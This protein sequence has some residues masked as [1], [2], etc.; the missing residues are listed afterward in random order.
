MLPPGPNSPAA[1]QI[2]QFTLRPLPYLEECLQR[3]GDPFTLR[4][5]SLGTYVALTAPELV[6]Q[7]FTAGSDQLLAG[8]ANAIVEPIVGKQSILLTDGAT[9]L[10]KRRL[11]MPPLH[12]DRMH[13]YGQVMADIAAE[14]L[15]RMPTGSVFSLHPHMQSI[16]MKVILRTVFGVER[17]SNMQELEQLLTA[18]LQ[19]PPAVLTFIPV[20]YLDFPL[21]PYRTLMRRRKAVE[22]QLLDLIHTARREQANAPEGA[23]ASPGRL[24]VLSLLVAARDE[25]GKAMSDAELVDELMTLL[26]AGHETTTTSLAWT[27]ACLHEHPEAAA[28]L[29]AELAA[30]KSGNRGVSRGGIAG[31][32]VSSIDRLPYLDAVVRESL[33]LRP[34][35]PDVVR[36]TIAPMTVGGYDIPLGTSLMPCIYLAHQRPEAYPAPASFRPE[37]FL[38]MKADPYTWFPFGGGIRRCVGMAFALYEMKVVLAELLLGARFELCSA[39]PIRTVRRTITLAPEHGVRVRMQRR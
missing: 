2:L 1:V 4:M 33:R 8:E 39:R 17:G 22:E 26:V 7:A 29:D 15:E 30:A 6:K 21:S 36:K 14:E 9:H 28:A 37:R 32:D 27:M 35:L 12:G 19:P 5:G 24:D 34:I 31:I 3:Y 18:F 20:K 38:G 23:H 11:L 25:D 16:T 10:R 13:A